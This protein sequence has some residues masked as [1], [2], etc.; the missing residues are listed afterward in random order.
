[1]TT[2]AVVSLGHMGL[3]LVVEFGKKYE[4]IGYDLSEAKIASHRNHCDPTGEVSTEDLKASTRLSVTTD[5]AQL[6][7]ADF[8]V[9]AVPTP[10]DEAHQPNLFPLVT[11]STAVGRQMKKVAVVVFESTVYPEPQ[12]RV[13]PTMSFRVLK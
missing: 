2:V 1:M 6:A 10:V 13:Q 4:T 11:S 8:I 7:K 9:V 3:P 12:K 5:Q